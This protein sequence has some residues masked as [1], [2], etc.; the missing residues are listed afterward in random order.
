MAMKMTQF[1]YTRGRNPRQV[2]LLTRDMETDEITQSGPVGVRVINEWDE[3]NGEVW[4][5]C[6]KLEGTGESAI[7]VF[8]GSFAIM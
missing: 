6:E 2:V 3:E 8:Y 5:V 7:H 1:A 4:M